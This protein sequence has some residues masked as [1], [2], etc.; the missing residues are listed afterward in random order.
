MAHKIYKVSELNKYINQ[1]LKSDEI[2][3][4]IYIKGEISNFYHHN[5]GHM[6][7]TI[8]DEKS[9]VKAVM[10]KSSNKNL[11][12]E[13]KDGLEVTASGYIGVYEPR[14]QY[15]FYVNDITPKGKGSLHLA[16]EQLKERLEK[17]GLFSQE[18]KSDIPIIPH[19]IGVVTS[20]TGAAIRD[21][22]SV[23]K[24]RFENVSLLIVPSLVQGDKASSQIVSG[25]N[26]L[27]DRDDIDLII[28][29]RGGGSIEQLWAFNEEKVAKAIF[30]SKIPVISG[31]GHETDFTI[32]DF[33]AD[34]RAP[35]P[36][37]AAELA[38]SNKVDL[39]NKLDNLTDRLEKTIKTKIKN[40]KDN[41]KSIAERQV[42]N[43]PEKLFSDKIQ[44][45]DNLSLKLG[46][47]IKENLND[48]KKQFNLLNSKLDSL[49]PLKT[50]KR[51]YS[52]LTDEDNNT[53]KSIEQ[54]E[55][56]DH[57]YNILEDGKIKSK[58]LNKEGENFAEKE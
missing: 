48:A 18:A 4:N 50:I 35:T 52:V 45:L 47:N 25:V 40:R 58:V 12:Y 34:L 46:W 22:L 23:V 13:L 42:F 44:K 9:A 6:Y 41:L 8:K 55:K 7:F 54:I 51:G 56:E 33:V 10:F 28:V 31:V 20:P 43:K 1:V 32:S 19:K 37:A 30:N 15:Q 53:V 16:Y 49:S 11:K 27:N 26:Y 29:S 57:I 17:E 14:G 38:I 36:S 39:E 3:Q 24:R 21:I 5:S 2:L